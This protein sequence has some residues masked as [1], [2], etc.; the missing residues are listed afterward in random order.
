MRAAAGRR[1]TPG[2][3]RRRARTR[4]EA[5]SN[6]YR[7]AG[8]HADAQRFLGAQTRRARGGVQA[9]ACRR[10]EAL[11]VQ[12]R[13]QAR[14]GVHSPR[15][16]PRKFMQHRRKTSRCTLVR[17]SSPA[18]GTQLARRA[19]TSE[20]ADIS[21]AHRRARKGNVQVRARA[22]EERADA[23]SGAHRL[24]MRK[25]FDAPCFNAYA[26]STLI[27]CNGQGSFTM[28]SRHSL[29]RCLSSSGALGV[30][31]RDPEVS[32][33]AALMTCPL[34]ARGRRPL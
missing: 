1:S 32:S 27:V 8:A 31:D 21:G 24:V 26:A 22:R 25:R 18:G 6:A 19:N 5:R 29:L 17:S 33:Q 11:G 7:R 4:A 10:A 28:P 16:E 30:S 13:G 3:Q 12:E 14:K 34:L 20:S 15:V 2:A 23:R 9:R